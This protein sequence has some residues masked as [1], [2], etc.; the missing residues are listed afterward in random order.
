MD[1]QHRRI[2]YTREEIHISELAYGEFEKSIILQ[3]RLL[4]PIKID[5]LSYYLSVL[6]KQVVI[7]AI[8]NQPKRKCLRLLKEILIKSGELRIYVLS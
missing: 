4:I 6:A 7:R 3:D 2:S 1:G 8:N 5:G